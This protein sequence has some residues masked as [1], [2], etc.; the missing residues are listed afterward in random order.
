MEGFHC[1]YG[2]GKGR[3]ERRGG[4]GVCGYT[5][6]I[7]FIIIVLFITELCRWGFHGSPKLELTAKPKFGHREVKLSTVTHWIEK[8]LCEIVDVSVE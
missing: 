2:E 6:T 1:I 5:S 8:K 3:S 7:K 4:R